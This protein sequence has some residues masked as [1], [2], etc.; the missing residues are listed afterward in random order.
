MEGLSCNRDCGLNVFCHDGIWQWTQGSCP[1]CAAPNTPIATP[2]GDRPIAALAVGD[3]VYSVDHE[4]IVVVPIA[5]IGRT[6]V[7]SHRVVTVELNDGSVLEMSPGH[8]FANGFAFGEIT[9]GTVVDAQR[10]VVSAE[11]VPYGFE[12]TYDILPA[13]SS[14]TYYAAGVPIAST[15]VD[16]G[17]FGS[18]PTNGPAHSALTSSAFGL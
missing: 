5:R 4:A 2:A 11:L 16:V 13:S 6:R 7:T 14:G 8:R 18:A 15:L 10:V 17:S 1:I 12:A 3:L 9:P